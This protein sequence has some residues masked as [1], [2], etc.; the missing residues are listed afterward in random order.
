MTLG[1]ESYSSFNSSM[2]NINS[3]YLPYDSYSVDHIENRNNYRMPAYHRLDVSI[4]LKEKKWGN[5]L[6][7]LE[8]TMPTTGKTLFLEFTRDINGSPRLSQYS[9][10]PLIPS[11]TYSFKF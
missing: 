5:E 7:V 1:L 10:F 4:N 3:F 6:G 11:F 2:E 9:L 8:S